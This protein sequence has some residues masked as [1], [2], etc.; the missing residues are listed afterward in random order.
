[1]TQAQ[2]QS[3]LEIQKK[4]YEKFKSQNLK[5]DM[6][7]GKPDS[8]QLSLSDPMLTALDSGEKCVYDGFD[9]RNYGILDGIPAAKQMLADMLEVPSENIIVCGKAGK[10]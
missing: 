3:E 1:M 5:L 7:R 2:L 9:M 8:E 6:S 4:L 10:Y